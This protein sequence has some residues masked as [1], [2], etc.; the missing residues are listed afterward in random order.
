MYVCM[1]QYVYVY[2]LWNVCVLYIRTTCT[3]YT[4]CTVFFVIYVWLLK[5]LDDD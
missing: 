5:P 4:V 1:S 3:M 2:L